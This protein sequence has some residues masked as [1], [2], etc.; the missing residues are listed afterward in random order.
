MASM[1]DVVAHAMALHQKGDEDGAAAVFEKLLKAVPDEPLALEYLGMRAGKKGDY[2]TAIS[3]FRQAVTQEKCRPAVRLQLAHAIRDSGQLT[4]SVDTYRLYVTETSDPAGAVALAEVLFE[5]DREQDAES[6]LRQAIEW[7][8]DHLKALCLLARACDAMEKRADAE[9]FRNTALESEES[10]KL[11][12]LMKA[13]VHLDLGNLDEAFSLVPEGVNSLHGD[14]FDAAC[15]AL[16]L[17]SLPEPQGNLPSAMG[18]PLIVAS[19]DP[20]FVQRYGPDLIRSVGTNSPSTDV[21]IHV[22]V[23]NNDQPPALP[24]DLPAHSLSW[25]NDPAANRVSFSTRRFVRA[26]ALMRTLDRPLVLIDIDSLVKKD[27]AAEKSKLAEF[28]VA[29]R[30]RAEEI[31]LNQR[32]CAGFLA[33]TPTPAAQSFIE[34]VAAYIL[35]FEA[36]GTAVWSLD[37]MALLAARCRFIG[38]DADPLV[39]IADVPERFL[40]WRRHS[41]DS[42]LWTTKGAGKALPKK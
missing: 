2:Q 32:V 37:Q 13:T 23:P 15:A 24:G 17:S 27:V 4:D 20:A 28:D 42:V 35:H 26:A 39:R 16:D 12:S 36:A 40:D 38:E 25:E 8:P 41:A 6:I 3:L 1:K 18:V 5:L 9:E 33:L 34:A 14:A 22:V 10:T 11:A 29:M 21:H 7:K 31:V 30:Y 19:G